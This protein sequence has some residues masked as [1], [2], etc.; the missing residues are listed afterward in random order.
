MNPLATLIEGSQ[1]SGT[2]LARQAGTYTAWQLGQP[3]EAA[4]RWK[5]WT[6]IVDGRQG[7]C[8]RLADPP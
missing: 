4:C 5:D 7:L 1:G 8:S 6:A 3:A 2:R